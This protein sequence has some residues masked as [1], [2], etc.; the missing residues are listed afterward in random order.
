MAARTALH[1]DDVWERLESVKD[2]VKQR[3]QIDLSKRDID[4]LLDYRDDR[5]KLTDELSAR[6]KE[7]ESIRKMVQYVS[8]PSVRYVNVSVRT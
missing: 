7:L 3:R 4:L 5:K 6:N 1:V 2:Y 8:K